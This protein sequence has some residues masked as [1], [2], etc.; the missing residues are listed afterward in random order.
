MKGEVTACPRCGSLFVS[1]VKQ[2]Q[3]WMSRFGPVMGIVTCADCGYEGLPI[4]LDSEEKRK[5]LAKGLKSIKAKGVS[6]GFK[7]KPTNT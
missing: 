7:R 2:G 3:P 4:I 1:G 6:A 5:A